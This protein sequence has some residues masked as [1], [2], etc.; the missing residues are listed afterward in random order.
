MFLVGEK[1]RLQSRPA[2]KAECPVCKGEREFNY[3]SE[4]SWFTLFALPVL[5]MEQLA[6]YTV[7]TVCGYAFQSEDRLPVHVSLVKTVATYLLLGYGLHTQRQLAQQICA[8]VTGFELVDEELK[9]LISGLE[10]RDIDITEVVKQYSSKTNSQGKAEVIEAAFLMTYVACEI[11]YEDRL[12]IN[13]MAN[14][15]GV[16]L[17]FVEAVIRRVRAQGYYGIQ[18]HLQTSSDL[19]H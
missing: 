10:A 5:P 19:Q 3:E 14:A 15:L 6:D 8:A 7:C 1:V 18:R 16:G 13:L 4:T 12:R 2:G 9:Q 17:E 11:E